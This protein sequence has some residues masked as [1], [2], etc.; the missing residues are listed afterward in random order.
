VSFVF[1]IKSDIKVSE[2]FRT[3]SL[4]ICDVKN[5]LDMKNNFKLTHNNQKIIRNNTKKSNSSSRIIKSFKELIVIYNNNIK[6]IFILML[7]SI[8]SFSH[9]SLL[10]TTSVNASETVTI[11]EGTNIDASVSPDQ[12]EIVI[13][14]QGVFWILPFDGG[15]AERITDN[16]EDPSFPDW[17]IEDRIIYQSYKDGNFHIWSMNSD[18]SD[19]EQLTEGP[20][21]HRYP[22]VSPDGTKVA[23]A[24]DEDGTYSIYVL[25]LETK[26]KSQWTESDQDEFH[27]SWSPDGN[28]IAFVHEEQIEAVDASG[29]R[30]VLIDE[31]K[32]LEFP[33]WAP[34]GDKIA[35]LSDNNIMVS[36]EQ[37][38]DEDT[39]VFSFAVDW[40]SEDEFVY[41]ADGNIMKHNIDKEKSETIPFSADIELNKQTYDYKDHD[42]DSEDERDVK[43]I[44]S[45][46]LSPNGEQVVFVAQNDLWLWD[47]DNK[48]PKA[49]TDDLYLEMNPTWSPDGNEI[50]YSSDKNGTQDIYILNVDSKEEQQLTSFTDKSVRYADFSPDGDKI[51]FQDQ[52]GI[53]YVMQLE[54]E[55]VEQITEESTYPNDTGP[56]TW[57]PNSDILVFA[58]LNSYTDRYREGR[59][60]IF[61]INIETG[62]EEYQAPLPDDPHKSLSNRENSGPVWSPDGKSMAFIIESQLY[63][64]PVDE[65]GQLTGEP[66]KITDEIAESI[67]W[68]GDSNELLYL[69]KG[70]FKRVSIDGGEPETLSFSMTWTP[71]KPEGKKIIKAG[72]LWDGVNEEIQED[73]DIIVENNRIVEIRPSQE[74][75]ESVDGE[76]IDASNL[77]VMPGLWDT[78]VHQQMARYNFGFGSNYG[79]QML[80]FGITSTMTM[81]DNAY[82]SLEEKE[83]LQSGAALGPRLFHSGEMIEGSRASYDSLRTT[84][85]TG[86][87]ERELERAKALDYDIL[88]TYVRFP[89]N[90]QSKVIDH[91]HEMG[92]PTFSHYFYPQIDYGKDGTSHVSATQREFSRTMSPGGNAYE[93]V[94]KLL[95]ASGMSMTS[96]LFDDSQIAYYP[97][98]FSS[99]SRI[100][101][102]F[103]P[104][105]YEA[106]ESSFQAVSTDQHSESLANNVGILKDVIDE[107][108]VV[109]AGSDLPI[110]HTS[111]ALHL[112]LKGMADYGMTNH[113]ALRT[114][115]YYPAKQMG[116][117][118]D[119]GTIEEGK[120]A[121]LV[122]VEG[123]PLQEISDASNVQMVMKNGELFTIEDL[124]KND[125]GKV[126]PKTATNNY[127]IVLFGIIII[128]VGG[129]LLIRKR[130][131]NNQ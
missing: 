122:L 87:V 99:D 96:T 33:S 64:V 47:I 3:F 67:S 111:I 102:F 20:Y 23:F 78:H 15:E 126:L 38:T 94:I 43:G 48:E 39:D 10:F 73:M 24:S 41:T 63:V 93:D 27:P 53:T 118:D 110:A 45:P 127:T 106:L 83:S 8:L 70:E 119:L 7:I 95:G 66:N 26:E 84:T 113:E 61:T 37:I 92:I 55:E 129:I 80:S 1:L 90:H 49:L 108:G 76:V 124:A 2:I 35:Y 85:S 65:N 50:A 31:G 60:Q 98:L 6:R 30:R 107:G 13:D 12:T 36:D 115:T 5:G 51:A 52:D 17:S 79:K 57:G 42:F 62:E 4:R 75:S 77:T 14:L 117:L 101:Q 22:T 16:F 114:A 11:T 18:G 32:N 104:W 58:A 71:K 21:D 74:D 82:M 112:N 72:A 34:E 109:L 91:A 19:Q 86:A 100:D 25:D 59:S 131:I 89:N 54:T 88:K 44:V 116:V 120:L 68:N 28:E 121:D 123:E 29:E 56:P 9:W 97:E 130:I 128:I 81:G 125:E 40:L 69:S 46:E 105:Q 103:T